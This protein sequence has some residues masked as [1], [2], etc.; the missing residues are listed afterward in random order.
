MSKPEL[1]S[2]LNSLSL[3][4]S[5]KFS[6]N[7]EEDVAV[8]TAEKTISEV[9]QRGSLEDIKRLHQQDESKLRELDE[10]GWSALHY[11]SRFNQCHIIEYLVE[12]RVDVNLV[13]EDDVTPLHL[14][15][16]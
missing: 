8:H 6:L 1:S 11:A 9:C 13:A 12:V 3:G 5:E 7:S 2:Q 16:R 15:V 10:N 4:K 14:A